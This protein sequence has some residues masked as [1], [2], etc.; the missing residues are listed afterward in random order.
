L[1]SGFATVLRMARPPARRP[2]LAKVLEK[3]KQLGDLKP[4]RGIAGKDQDNCSRLGVDGQ[5]LEDALA[6][7]HVDAAGLY[8][9]DVLKRT[10]LITRS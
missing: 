2:G 8:A 6:L 9:G 5:E 1:P 10:P 3:A 4:N 7:A